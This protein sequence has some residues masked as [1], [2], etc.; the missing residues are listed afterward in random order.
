MSA[1]DKVIEKYAGVHRRYIVEYDAQEIYRMSMNMFVYN[2]T[3]FEEIESVS[4]VY[5]CECLQKEIIIDV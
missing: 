5:F 1:L 2:E 4:N 3:E